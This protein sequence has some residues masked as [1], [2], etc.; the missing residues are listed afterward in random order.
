MTCK[1]NTGTSELVLLQLLLNSTKHFTRW[2]S[3]QNYQAL[4]YVVFL[5]H[6]YRFKLI[7][8][9]VTEH[10]GT[11]ASWRLFDLKCELILKTK[12]CKNRKEKVEQIKYL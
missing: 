5:Q 6:I 10:A 9:K 11:G 8:F 4:R 2:I 3:S 12:V 1:R 7:F